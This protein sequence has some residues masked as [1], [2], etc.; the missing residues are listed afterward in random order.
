MPVRRRR[1]FPP[2][3]STPASTSG[4]T[5]F[6]GQTYAVSKD[7]QRFLVNARTPQS[8]S[9]PPLN[10]VVNWMAAIQTIAMALTP[11]A[12]LGPYEVLAP[13]GAGGMGEVYRARDTKLGRDVAL[14]TLPASF[15]SDAEAAGAIRARGQDAGG[16][17]SSRTS[18]TFTASSNPASWPALVMELVEGDD[19]SQSDRPRAAVARR[20]VGHRAADR[21]SARGRPRAG[22]H[23]PRSQARQHQAARRRRREGAG[24]RA[25]QGAGAGVRD[26]PTEDRRTWRTRR[27]SPRRR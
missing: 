6:P 5:A 24:L 1:S 2:A 26:R 21:R 25:R 14:K 3:C 13:L 20:R 19:L 12:R 4:Q 23:P 17:E 27:P 22:D 9:V 11:G 18:P 15:A 10:V 8:G 7:G 16:A